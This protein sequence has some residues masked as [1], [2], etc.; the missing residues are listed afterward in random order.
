MAVNFSMPAIPTV[1]LNSVAWPSVTYSVPGVPSFT[2]P[3]LGSV[4][5]GTPPEYAGLDIP[6]PVYQYPTA[7][8]P[9][10]AVITI[11]TPPSIDFEQFNIDVPD[12]DLK[13]PDG[14]VDWAY[15]AYL[16]VILDTLA[17]Q[18]AA[19]NGV[20][21][22]IWGN[23]ETVQ[24]RIW[25]DGFNLIQQFGFIDVLQSFKSQELAYGR[26]LYAGAKDALVEA[27][28][29]RNAKT[30]LEIILNIEKQK[31]TQYA[32][33]KDLELAFAKDVIAKSLENYSLM[34]QQYGALIDKYKTLSTIFQ[35]EIAIEEQKLKKLDAEITAEKIKGEITKSLIARYEAQVSANLELINLYKTQMELAKKLTE[36]EALHIDAFNTSIRAFTVGVQNISEQAQQQFYAARTAVTMARTDEA[37]LYAGELSI[38]AATLQTEIAA[39]QDKMN[40]ERMAVD[41]RNQ[42]MQAFGPHMTK[43]A[44]IRGEEIDMRELK[45]REQERA[46]LAEVQSELDIANSRPPIAEADFNSAVGIGHLRDRMA[47]AKLIH[48]H[49][50]KN[51]EYQMVETGREKAKQSVA[52]TLKKAHII[53]HFIEH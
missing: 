31:R 47:T 9:A 24:S 23:W 3:G 22:L 45:A 12:P 20:T 38:K 27:Y 30:Y 21:D 49:T 25:D 33:Q 32:Q 16:G 35:G 34:I 10:P 17:I 28:N 15:Q 40:N 36:A 46:R 13:I 52:E 4:D 44:T 19:L 37:Q 53:N 41:S 18:V 39:L 43:E 6:Q 7:E 2:Y 48:E 42:M 29:A 8:I 51:L 11:P 26:K 50:I 1:S 5:T 14:A